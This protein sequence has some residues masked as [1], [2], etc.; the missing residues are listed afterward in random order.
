MPFGK[1]S[2]SLSG[3]ELGKYIFQNGELFLYISCALV[4][5]N[6]K[7]NFKVSIILESL[8]RPVAEPQKLKKRSV[9]C[10]QVYREKENKCVLCFCDTHFPRPSKQKEPNI[11][12][13]IDFLNFLLKVLFGFFF[14][15]V[16]F[17]CLYS[18]LALFFLSLLYSV[19]D[20]VQESWTRPHTGHSDLP[21]R[22]RACE[23]PNTYA[24]HAHTNIY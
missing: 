24:T 8:S 21:E 18:C 4:R 10:F 7:L 15:P 5:L 23:L 12:Q 13:R 14:S 22:R 16:V 2:Y 11:T 9:T 17:F 20:T 3:Q 1:Y 19:Y 6:S